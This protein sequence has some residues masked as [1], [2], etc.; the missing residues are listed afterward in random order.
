MDTISG[1]TALNTLR[2][3]RDPYATDAVYQVFKTRVS[4]LL[5]GIVGEVQFKDAMCLYAKV[6]SHSSLQL[7]SLVRA[8]T[9]RLILIAGHGQFGNSG[10][11]SQKHVAVGQ[12]PKD[13]DNCGGLSDVVKVSPS[14][15]GH[16]CPDTILGK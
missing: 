4:N 15:T 8:G 5:G 7:Q 11:I 6:V 1:V 10:Q 13:N 3:G 9:E 12:M 14:F 2:L 16:A